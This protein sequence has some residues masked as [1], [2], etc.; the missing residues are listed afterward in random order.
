VL[1]LDTQDFYYSI[2][3]RCGLTYSCSDFRTSVSGL[4]D[5]RFLSPLRQAFFHHFRQAFSALW[6]KAMRP[7][8]G[9]ATGT[10]A[11]RGMR[12]DNCFE[13]GNRFFQ[14]VPLRS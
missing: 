13:G 4:C 8:P 7:S 9:A 6:S 1:L 10:T 12:L 11:G 14:S 5:L 2:L 3:L